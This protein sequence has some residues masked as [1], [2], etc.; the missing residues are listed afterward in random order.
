M[1]ILYLVLLVAGVC[2]FALSYF[3]QFR[4]AQVM[5]QR[6]P[7]H[8]QIIAEPDAGKAS[9]LRTWIRMQHAFRSPAMPALGDALIDRWLRIWRYSP[10][11][12]WICW[13]AALGMRL[14]LS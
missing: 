3:A 12:G 10:W 6:Y 4:L 14:L 9:I 2:L 1:I 5:K 7:Q 8:W 11:L 13:L